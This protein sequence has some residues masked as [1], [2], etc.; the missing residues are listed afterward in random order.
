MLAVRRRWQELL[1][2]IFLIRTDQP[3]WVPAIFWCGVAT[4]SITVSILVALRPDRLDDLH[5]VRRWLSY[6]MAGTG[7]PYDRFV[8]LDYPPIAFLLLWPLGLPSD[9]T[10]A[11]WF[12]PGV[13]VITPLAGWATLHWM[14]ER[15]Y[16][17]LAPAEQ[18]AL[19]A[20]MLSGTGMRS[21]TWLGQTVALSLLFGALAM[22]W[23]RRRPYAA[24]VALAL[25]SFKPHIAV[26]FGLAILLIKGVD[27]IILAAAIVLSLSLLF[28]ATI[29]Q[30]LADLAADWIRNLMTLYAGPDRVRG[31]LSVRFV[32]D[33]IIGSYVVSSALY[34]LLAVATLAIIVWLSRRRQ[35][36]AVTH[37]QVAVACLLWSVLF[38]PHQL[39]NSLLAAPALWLL[40]WPEAGLIARRSVRVAACA[41]YV[42]FGVF[43]VAGALRVISTFTPEPE[44]VYRSSY[45]LSPLRIACV[46]VVL[47]WALYHR[48]RV[49]DPREDVAA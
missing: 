38:L 47:L 1:S 10:L 44:W 48:P 17:A 25:C 16:V 26:G 37:T 3:T 33:D 19:I 20:L 18:I 43:D 45:Y 7:N 40:M 13:L 12:L 36:D 41:A 28:A 21:A 42:L 8:G 15:M 49:G 4:L 35:H 30:P 6:W 5:E 29:G 11:Y 22:R 24:A 39:Y 9:A 2:G 27:V 32:L 34:V 31:L 14:R 46:F 23:S